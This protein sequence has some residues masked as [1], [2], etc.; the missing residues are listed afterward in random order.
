VEHQNL[1]LAIKTILNEY[2]KITKE[3]VS[4][5]ELKKAK[6]FIKGKTVMS[7]EESDEVAMYFIEQEVSKGRI[8]A[9]REIFSRIDKVTPGD[10]IRV[11]RDIFKKNTLNL[12]V[13]GPYKKGKEL[14]KLLTL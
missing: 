13:I 10:I 11:A 4:T 5:K 12:A 9:P 7:L 3:K 8:L 6:D 1:E 14:E 2:K